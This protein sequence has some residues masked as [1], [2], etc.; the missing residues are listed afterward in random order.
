MTFSIPKRCTIH[1]VNQ[2]LRNAGHRN[3][4]I[5]HD[6]SNANNIAVDY[7]CHDHNGHPYYMTQQTLYESARKWAEAFYFGKFDLDN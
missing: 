2:A 1:S 3:V 7:L 6:A 5:Y 4:D